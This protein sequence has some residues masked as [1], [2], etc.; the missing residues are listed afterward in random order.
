VFREE[1]TGDQ[2]AGEAART[3]VL[4]VAPSPTCFSRSASGCSRAFFATPRADQL[5]LPALLTPRKKTLSPT[6]IPEIRTSRVS[7]TARSSAQRRNRNWQVRTRFGFA[8]IRGPV[9]KPPNAFVEAL[10]VLTLPVARGGS[11]GGGE[12][13][14]VPSRRIASFYAPASSAQRSICRPASRW[15]PLSSIRS[16]PTV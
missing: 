6:Q 8:D 11:S 14:P 7:I 2:Q 1:T 9:S 3:H 4:D 10:D 12:G 16:R 5:A 13:A 15:S